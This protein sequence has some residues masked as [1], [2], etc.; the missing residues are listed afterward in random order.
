MELDYR[1]ANNRCY[2]YICTI[3]CFSLIMEKYIIFT[4]SQLI[5]DAVDITNLSAYYAL[6]A[7]SLGKLL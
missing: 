5:K 7:E 1:C 6:E 3:T 4:K 2:N